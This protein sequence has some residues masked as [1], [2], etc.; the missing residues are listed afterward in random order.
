MLRRLA[1]ALLGSG[2]RRRCWSRVVGHSARLKGYRSGW[3]HS[4]RER[5]GAR[6]SDCLWGR[7]WLH[8]DLGGDGLNDGL[9][10]SR[11]CVVYSSG[12]G[13]SDSDGD[14][15]REWPRRVLG[16]RDRRSNTRLRRDDLISCKGLGSS[17]KGQGEKSYA[18]HVEAKDFE[19][20]TIVKGVQGW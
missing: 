16:Y 11:R 10:V 13:V 1:S 17:G 5:A 19:K 14:G 9:L 20:R 12:W 4:D 15:R 7:H 6:V 8:N 3:R 2:G 18:M